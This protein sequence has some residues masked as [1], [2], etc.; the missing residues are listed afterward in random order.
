MKTRILIELET[1]DD[2]KVLLEEGD[3][4]EEY[5]DQQKAKLITLR[6]GFAK[7]L[8]EKVRDLILETF[9]SDYFGEEVMDSMDEYYVEGWD[10]LSDYG[11]TITS[12][13]LPDKEIKE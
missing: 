7:G 5:N 8:H 11:I 2:Y 13:I 9:E 1:K 10:N 4:E 6:K 12:K 3:V